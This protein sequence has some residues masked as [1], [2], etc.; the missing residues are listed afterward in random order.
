MTKVSERDRI[1]AREVKLKGVGTETRGPGRRR[2]IAL[3]SPCSAQARG[4]HPCTPVRRMRLTHGAFG[5]NVPVFHAPSRELTPPLVL[6]GRCS[7][8]R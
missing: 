7:W 1:A 4:V 6:G 2:S 8:L 5:E 3:C